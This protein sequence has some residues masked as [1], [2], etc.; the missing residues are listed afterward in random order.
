MLTHK[1]MLNFYSVILW[2]FAISYYFF[3]TSLSAVPAVESAA[4]SRAVVEML[5]SVSQKF[6]HTNDVPKDRVTASLYHTIVRKLAHI[7]NY[8]I[9][10]FL[11][12]MLW[13]TLSRKN[14]CCTIA[15][16]LFLGLCGA[17][18]DEV[19]QLF[20]AGR[21]AEVLDVLI[22]FDGTCLGAV[23]FLLLGKAVK[24]IPDFRKEECLYEN[25]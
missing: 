24:I 20:F 17:A 4:D 23:F 10:A 25:I 2:I 21:S 13:F 3:I 9:F 7:A 22:D 11:N 18:M 15:L 5:D 6:F 8:Y 1:G 14:M 19:L 16:A 12:S